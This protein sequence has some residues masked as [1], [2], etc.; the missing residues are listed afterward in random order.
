MTSWAEIN[1]QSHHQ[2][3]KFSSNEQ[4]NAQEQPSKQSQA[5]YE[6][7]KIYWAQTSQLSSHFPMVKNKTENIKASVNF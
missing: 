3:Y 7:I 2:V 4:I 1:K 6:T 5:P